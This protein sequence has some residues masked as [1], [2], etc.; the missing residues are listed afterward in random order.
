[1]LKQ[2][3]NSNS[4]AKIMSGAP[5]IYLTTPLLQE[6]QSALIKRLFLD[7]FADESDVF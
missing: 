1:M 6:F 2:A 7:A 5:D 4:N 3:K